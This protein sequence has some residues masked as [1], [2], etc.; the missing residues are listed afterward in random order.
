MNLKN[1]IDSKIEEIKTMESDLTERLRPV[2]DAA[3]SL[4]R[5]PFIAEIKRR[6]PSLGEINNDLNIG[7]RAAA[8]ESGGAGAISVLT[9]KKY[10]DGDYL[11]LSEAA[12]AVKIS[13]LCKDFIMSEI[14]IENAYAAGADFI[15]L[16][17]RILTFEEI[18]RLARYARGLG[19]KILFELHSADEF[20]KIKCLNPEMVGINSR[21][22]SSLTIDKEAAAREI[23]LLNGD[24][25]KIAE[26]G[27]ET[28][29]DV[30]FFAAHGADAFLVGTAL[31]RSPDPAAK[32]AELYKGIGGGNVR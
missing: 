11:F 1:I 16:I 10:F 5:K 6:S 22:L 26:S 28:A 4:R 19:M 9:D 30:R 17:S 18:K 3:E 24:F 32:I 13:V 2:I 8:Y 12:G 15:L 23:S 25:I 7:A 21:D 31:M 14:Q 29:D 20:D 27:I